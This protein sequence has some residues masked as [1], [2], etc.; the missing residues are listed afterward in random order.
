MTDIDLIQQGDV[1]FFLQDTNEL[2]ECAVAVPAT[3]RGVV[4]AEGDVTGNSHLT[5]DA[6]VTLY[7]VD[8]EVFCVV[9]STATVVHQE[10]GDV[11][12]SAGIYRVDGVQEIDPF[13]KEIERVRD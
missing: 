9:E 11:F 10:H 6:G 13:T 12:L 8:D 3:S 4:F 1:L 5:T 2:P 7:N